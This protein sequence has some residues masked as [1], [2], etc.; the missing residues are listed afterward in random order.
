MSTKIVILGKPG[1][2][3]NGKNIRLEVDGNYC[4]GEINLLL[5]ASH[6]EVATATV[7][8]ILPE[9]EYRDE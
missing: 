9:I 8:M 6:N 2:A 7:T 1:D 5:T 4:D 3:I